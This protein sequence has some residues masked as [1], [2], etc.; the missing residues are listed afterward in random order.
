M[1]GQITTRA[2]DIADYDAAVAL[3]SKVEGIEI[4]EG[5]SVEDLTSY[6]VRNPGLSRVA[7]YRDA[8]VG[9]A[10]CGHDGRRGFIYHVAVDPAYQNKGIARRLIAECL[11]GLRNL[12]LKRALI[13]VAGDNQSGQMFWQRA[14]WENVP[15]VKV[16]GID[17]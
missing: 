4:A 9:V 3:W 13:L 10:L 14:G 11:E 5:D 1:I 17:L 8:V 6:L 12:G 7:V 16:M 15:G 2:F